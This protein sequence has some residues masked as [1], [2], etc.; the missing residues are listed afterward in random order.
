MEGRQAEQARTMVIA[1]IQRSRELAEEHARR[2]QSRG[3]R[4]GAALE[5]ERVR[6]AEELLQRLGSG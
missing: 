3:N 5:W 1:A 6:R 2:L 4:G